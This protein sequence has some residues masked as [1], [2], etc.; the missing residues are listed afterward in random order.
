MYASRYCFCDDWRQEWKIILIALSEKP[1]HKGQAFASMGELS[2]TLEESEGFLVSDH[3]WRSHH[4]SQQFGI[5]ALASPARHH[6][7]PLSVLCSLEIF[8]GI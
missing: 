7:N 5:P 3:Q 6:Q 1:L 8:P 2:G 4:W